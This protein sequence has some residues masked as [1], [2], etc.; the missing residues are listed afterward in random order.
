[1]NNDNEFSLGFMRAIF[2]RIAYLKY[3]RDLT[4]SLK[5]NAINEAIT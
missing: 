3:L 2:N 4:L 5:L 1:M